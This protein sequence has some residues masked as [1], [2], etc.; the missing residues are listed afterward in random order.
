MRIRIKF[1]NYY[2]E[3]VFEI[4]PAIQF[5]WIS[6]KSTCV[7]GWKKSLCFSWFFWGFEIIFESKIN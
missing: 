7:N 6:A 4:L 1:E 3:R 5:Q 2:T